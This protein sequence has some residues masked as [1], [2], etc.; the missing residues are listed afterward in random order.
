MA[1]NNMAFI[2]G[3][4][5]ENFKIYLDKSDLMFDQ[6]NSYRIPTSKQKEVYNEM[7]IRS[8]E[9]MYY[10]LTD[11]KYKRRNTEI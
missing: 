8:N 11:K 10:Q 3:S 6:Y 9:D 7:M 5:F 1:V 2:P 4:E